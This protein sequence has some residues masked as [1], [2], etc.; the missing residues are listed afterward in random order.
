MD[1]LNDREIQRLLKAVEEVQ[2]SSQSLLALTTTIGFLQNTDAD[3]KKEFKKLDDKI[4]AI[5]I[6][7]NKLDN[8]INDN[9]KFLSS[10]KWVLITISTILIGAIVVGLLEFFFQ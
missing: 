9:S 6:Q 4:E 8:K 7:I 10:F 1:P 5:K 3:N 2:K